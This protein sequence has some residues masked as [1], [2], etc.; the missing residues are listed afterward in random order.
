MR[1][2]LAVFLAVGGLAAAAAFPGAALAKKFP[3][4]AA[5]SCGTSSE[6]EQQAHSGFIEGGLNLNG[7]GGTFND[8]APGPN[9]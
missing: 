7:N 1:R 8:C 9:P 6:S 5:G 4:F 2:L 3:N